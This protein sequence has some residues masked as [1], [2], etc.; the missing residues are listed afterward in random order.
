M[1]DSDEMRRIIKV[2]I[3]GLAEQVYECTDGAAAVTAY[4]KYHPDWVLMD[5]K[6]GQVD[7]IIA[8]QQ[9]TSADPNAKVVIVTSYDETELQEDALNA[10]AYGYVLKAN[11]L[12]LLPLLE[13]SVLRR[14]RIGI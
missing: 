10:G 2:L 13:S 7:G 8:T 4:E 5:I 14:P 6:L 11:L 12:K 3:A 1:E 9:I